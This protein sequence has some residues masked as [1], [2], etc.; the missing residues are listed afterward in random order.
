M[1]NNA[2]C[3]LLIAYCLLLTANTVYLQSVQK[4]Q[5][6]SGGFHAANT[7]ILASNLY[8]VT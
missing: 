8:E 1:Q 4:K 7:L 3:L 2:Y 5:L 6:N